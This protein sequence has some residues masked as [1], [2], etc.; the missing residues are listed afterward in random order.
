MFRPSKL[1]SSLAIGMSVLLVMI[2]SAS[3]WGGR[4]ASE[5]EP[6]PADAPEA[7]PLWEGKAPGALGDEA[8]DRPS[9]QVYLPKSIKQTGAAVVVCPGGGYG[10]LADHEG[11]PVAE[12]LNDIGIVGIVLKYRLGP[13]YH[14]PIMLNDA[15]RAIR[16]VRA[17]ADEWKLDPHKIG[18]LGFSAGGHLASSAATH[19]D[20]GDPKAADPIDRLSSRPDAAMLIYPVITMTDP[21]THGGSRHNLLGDKPKSE[22]VDLM[23]NEKQVSPKTPPTFLVHSSDDRAVPVENSLM[24]ASALSKAGVPCE[25][26]V[27]AHGPHGFGLG[28][29]DPS[30]KTWPDLCAVWLKKIGFAK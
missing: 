9:I 10:M 1:S 8:G 19:F 18:I 25:L 2:A 24:F 23:S 28:G 17:H 27:Y 15:S 20:D 29:D 5:R 4:K 13:K 26:H 21:Y 6:S 12:R 30:L 22:L 11:R 14:H 3:V 16:F 7:I